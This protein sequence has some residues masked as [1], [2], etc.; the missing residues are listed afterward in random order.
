MSKPRK[1]SS[2]E[3]HGEALLMYITHHMAL[4]LVPGGDY[5][6]ESLSLGPQQEEYVLSVSESSL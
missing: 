1:Q 4:L 5:L 6:T 3:A 2:I